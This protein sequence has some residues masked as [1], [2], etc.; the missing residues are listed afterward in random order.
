MESNA[1]SNKR[2]GKGP[3]QGTWLPMKGVR[4]A[5]SHGQH[6]RGKLKKTQ[7]NRC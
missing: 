2:K 4:T 5:N 7:T 6:T 3:L 1:L